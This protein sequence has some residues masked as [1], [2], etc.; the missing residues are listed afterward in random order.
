MIP[1]QPEPPYPPGPLSAIEDLGV[2]THTQTDH[3]YGHVCKEGAMGIGVIRR[4]K[5]RQ[6]DTNQ[7]LTSIITEHKTTYML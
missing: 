6:K 1:E 2:L 4:W 3:P 7:C 5:S